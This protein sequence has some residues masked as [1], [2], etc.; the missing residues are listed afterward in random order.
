MLT[1]EE[2]AEIRIKLDERWRAAGDRARSFRLL[3]SVWVIRVVG[4]GSGVL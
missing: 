1:D 2:A 3:Q 4:R